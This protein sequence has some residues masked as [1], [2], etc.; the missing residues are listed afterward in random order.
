MRLPREVRWR[1]CDSCTVRG[2]PAAL[3]LLCADQQSVPTAPVGFH[4]TSESTRCVLCCAQELEE[5][6]CSGF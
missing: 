2:E 1:V 5:L 3:Q 6:R 4:E